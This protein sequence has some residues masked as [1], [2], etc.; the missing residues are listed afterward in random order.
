MPGSIVQSVYAVDD[1]G[2]T[3]T[4]I[5]ATINNVGA[6]NHLIAHAGWSDSGAVTA[7]CADPAVYS[8]A[9]P[10]RNDAGDGQS[11]QIFLSEGVTPG[12]HTVTVTLSITRDFR[13]LRVYEVA[14][15]AR[16]SVDQ[17]TGQS[18]TTPGTG[19]NAVSSGASSATTNA[20]D[21]VM[22]FSQNVLEND[23]GTGTVTAGT[24]YTI[25]GANLIMCGEFRSVTSTGAQTATFTQSVN[26]TRLTHVVAFK[27]ADSIG[28]MRGQGPGYGPRKRILSRATRSFE[29]AAS[30]GVL[31]GSTTLTFTP[32]GSL[33]GDGALTGSTTLT[34]APTATLTGT[35]PISGSST[36]TFSP[37]AT[38]TGTGALAGSSTLAFSPTSS[39]T[40]SGALSGTATI[41]FSPTGVLADAGSGSLVGASS[42][43]FTVVGTLTGTGD[44]AGS[45][46][47]TFSPAGILTNA[48]PVVSD[49]PSGGFF[50]DF[51][52]Y[53]AQKQRRKKRE[54]DELAEIKAIDEP[55]T[56][57]IAQL[58]RVQEARDEERAD[59][60]RLQS[61]ADQYAGTAQGLP[62]PITATLL[63]AYEERSRNAL[64][65]LQREMSQ[66]AD[67][68]DV[69]IMLILNS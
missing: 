21:F 22:G 42:F 68:E 8:T 13:R 59:L 44:L 46:T 67:E 54:Q 9:D 28:S 38:L 43:T 48:T 69:S 16:S 60:A 39:L 65:Q 62:R 41:T 34:F 25:S 23:P 56:R 50:Y 12:S 24:N 19:A 58:L 66:L 10:R 18:Q 1:S 45:T 11:G 14:N 31:S 47:L 36:L 53:R 51:D 7:S 2:G 17:S 5:A 35:A 27:E 20:R 55:T 61:L 30:A 4:T 40:G 37:T 32:T 15:L 3:A 52:H 49:Q 26:N 33:T 64:E 57:E 6:G 63:K 29:S